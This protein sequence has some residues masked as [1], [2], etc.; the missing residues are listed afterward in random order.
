MSDLIFFSNNRKNTWLSKDKI[1][2]LAN[3]VILCK[4]I[5]QY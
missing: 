3:I 5:L 1:S 4:Y 2:V